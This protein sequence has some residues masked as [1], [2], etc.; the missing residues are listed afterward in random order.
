MK[1]LLILSISITFSAL[2][3]NSTV[4]ESVSTGLTVSVTPKGGKVLTEPVSK[5]QKSVQRSIASEPQKMKEMDGDIC[6]SEK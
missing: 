6:T 2:A 4:I 5:E 3:M 1:Y